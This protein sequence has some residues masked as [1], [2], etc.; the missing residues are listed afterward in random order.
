M[1]PRKQFNEQVKKLLNRDNETKKKHNILSRAKYEQTMNEVKLAIALKAENK[2]LSPKQQRRFKRYDIVDKGYEEKM[3]DRKKANS[4]IIRYHVASDELFDIISS[5]DLV[6]RHNQEKGMFEE[7]KKEYA[8]ITKEVI[9]LYVKLCKYCKAKKKS[10]RKLAAKPAA[11][12][13]MDSRCHV[14]LIDMQSK[15]DGEFN[16]ILNYKDYITKYSVLQPLKTNAP[17]EVADKI[18]HI[19]CLLGAPYIILSDNGPDF[20]N[21]VIKSLKIKWPELNIVHGSQDSVETTNKVVKKALV[22]WMTQEKTKKWTDGL[23]TV[24]LSINNTYEPC[25]KQS[26]FVNLFGP[27]M[28]RKIPQDEDSDS[29]SC[30]IVINPIGLSERMEYLKKNIKTKPV[31]KPCIVCDDRAISLICT[32]CKEH[33]HGARSYIRVVGRTKKQVVC[34][35]CRRMEN[36][37]EK[38]IESNKRARETQSVQDDDRTKKIKFENLD[39]EIIGNMDV[40]NEYSLSD[41]AEEKMLAIELNKAFYDRPRKSSFCGCKKYCRPQTCLC[42]KRKTLCNATCHNYRSCSN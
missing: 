3:I 16:F 23:S 11:S 14:S 5:L 36:V 20:L 30:G 12:N 24:Q 39:N 31:R 18:K 38:P 34:L 28:G 4:G 32:Q 1:T 7:L 40:E 25:I 41:D 8:N 19:F 27:Y 13:L 2:A 15:N 17:E 26:P 9:H 21:S 29:D 42:I 37:D 22:S 6:T 10:M 35:F 33:L